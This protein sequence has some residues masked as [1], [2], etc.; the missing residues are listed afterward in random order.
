MLRLWITALGEGGGEAVPPLSAY[1]AERLA[2]V[3][4]A[5]L[6]AQML[7]AERLLVRALSDF[8]IAPPLDIAVTA[9]GKPVLRGGEV[10]FNL[11]HSAPYVACAVSDGDIGLDIQTPETLRE[12]LVRRFFTTE[13]QRLLRESANPDADFTALWC[14]KESYLKAL[15]TGLNKPLGSFSVRLGE[16]PAMEEDSA[17]RFWLKRETRFTLALCTLDA[18]PAEP[19]SIVWL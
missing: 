13:E 18:R 1:R 14:C 19:D 3:R 9:Q 10:H 2:G 5:S 15:G 11:S 6:R 4:S 17:V 8:G 7:A 12:S 16:P